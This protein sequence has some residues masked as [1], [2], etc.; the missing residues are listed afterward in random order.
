MSLGRS[1]ELTYM[2]SV[3]MKQLTVY[4]KYV[5]R[6]QNNNYMVKHK[7]ETHSQEVKAQIHEVTDT[8]NTF[9]WRE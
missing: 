5:L 4:I 2:K 9:T 8:W 7:H 3:Y 6:G 1:H